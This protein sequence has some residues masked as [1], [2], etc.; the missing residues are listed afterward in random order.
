MSKTTMQKPNIQKILLLIFSL[1]NFLILSGLIIEF[2]NFMAYKL[3]PVYTGLVDVTIEQL[4]FRDGLYFALPC[5][6]IA[7]FIANSARSKGIISRKI[8]GFAIAISVIGML[9]GVLD[10]I[11]YF[12]VSAIEF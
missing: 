10:L 3:H 12:M 11:Y 9:F 6:V 2:I 7:L 1:P 8:T 4:V 5:G